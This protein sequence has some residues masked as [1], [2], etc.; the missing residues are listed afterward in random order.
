MKKRLHQQHPPTTSQE[1]MK[2]PPPMGVDCCVV[3]FCLYHPDKCRNCLRRFIGTNRL[4]PF[5]IQNKCL[6]PF[7]CLSHVNVHA[8]PCVVRL[9]ICGLDVPGSCYTFNLQIHAQPSS[10]CYLVLSSLHHTVW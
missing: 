5:N 4:H 9:A 7:L 1:T 10:V 6:Y 2:F 3:L 8:N